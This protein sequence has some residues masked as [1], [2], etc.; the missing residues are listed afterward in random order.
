MSDNRIQDLLALSHVP[1]WGVVP[2][3]RPQS[4]AEHSFRVAAIAMEI[5]RYINGE[6]LPSAGIIEYH[7][8]LWALVHDA[9]ESETGDFPSTIKDDFG[10]KILK[11]FEDARCPWIGKMR[12]RIHPLEAA[13]VGVADK[14]EAILWIRIWGVGP[15]ARYA[16]ERD[17][18]ILRARVE[19][20]RSRFGLS[21]LP[22][23]VAMLTDLDSILPEPVPVPLQARTPG[24]GPKT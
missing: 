24:L 16:E 4:V 18:A 10:V 1:R 22:E 3:T 13:I 5:C 9:P 23:I 12:M 11:V 14:I 7:V 19:E 6:E 17:T 8:I 2:V 15:K 20:A 21:L